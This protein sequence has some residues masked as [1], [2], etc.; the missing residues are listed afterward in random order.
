MRSA[1][2]DWSS[3]SVV[4]DPTLQQSSFDLTRKT[5]SLLNCLWTGQAP[6][7]INLH[8]L[9][10]NATVARSRPQTILST[11]VH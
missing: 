1:E 7:H 8:K 10:R 2:E 6:C 9:G 3:A 5:W 4:T 11:R